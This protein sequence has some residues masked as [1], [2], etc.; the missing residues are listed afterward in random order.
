MD[1][2]RGVIF[3]KV[4]AE[5]ITKIKVVARVVQCVC[6]IGG[7]SLVMNVFWLFLFVQGFSNRVN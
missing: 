1:D 6:P 2:R 7:I 4:D 5:A 3:D